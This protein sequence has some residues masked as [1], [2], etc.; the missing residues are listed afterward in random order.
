VDQGLVRSIVD[1][2][3]RLGVPHAAE[4]SPLQRSW[5]SCR[6]SDAEILRKPM[7]E[8]HKPGVE[9]IDENSG[10]P[11]VRLRKRQKQ[12]DRVLQYAAATAAVPYRRRRAL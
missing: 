11:G 4:T 12:K 3:N 7:S 2:I 10:G 5:L 8:R 6:F 1:L 9:F